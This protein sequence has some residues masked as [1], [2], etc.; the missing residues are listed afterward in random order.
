MPTPMLQ[1]MAAKSGKSLE[2]V[3]KMWA[4]AKDKAH[5]KKDTQDFYAYTTGIL[6]NMLGLTDETASVKIG[7]KKYQSIYDIPNIWVM[8]VVSNVI[9]DAAYDPAESVLYVNFSGNDI[10]TWYMYSGVPIKVFV[11]FTLSESK[12]TYFARKI[13]EKYDSVKISAK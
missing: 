1:S 10:K 7:G 6:K 12:G 13:K 8:N 11:E 5:G 2:E 3:E 9:E 4:E